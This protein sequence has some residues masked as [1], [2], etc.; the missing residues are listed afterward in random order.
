M[1]ERFNAGL[2]FGSGQLR[3]LSETEISEKVKR[4]LSVYDTKHLPKLLHESLQLAD[5]GATSTASVSLPAIAQRTV[6]REA[7]SDLKILDLVSVVIDGRASTTIDIP[8][9][10]RKPGAIE[11]AGIVYEGNEIPRASIEQKMDYAY[12]LAMKLCFEVTN[13]VAFFSANSPMDWDAVSRNI[14]SNAKVIRELI[15]L[16]IANEMQRSADAFG[17]T[18]GVVTDISSQLTGSKS[19]VKT[20]SFPIVRPKTVF[21]IDGTQVGDTQNP[22]TVI[23]NDAEIA[24]FNGTGNQTAGI[25][26]RVENYNLGLIRLVDQA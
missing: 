7:L 13:E 22:M 16:R 10:L 3:R 17:A 20:T 26:Y 18:A 2:A 12:L 1:Q 24:A 8:Y 23:L 5:G 6:I 14:E 4:V 11:K 21:M 25:Y 19:L 15:A 9:E